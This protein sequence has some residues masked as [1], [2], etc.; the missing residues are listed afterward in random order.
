MYIFKYTLLLPLVPTFAAASDNLS[1]CGSKESL[2][3]ILTTD[4]IIR[5]LKYFT[6]DLA[7]GVRGWSKIFVTVML[8][9]RHWAITAFSKTLPDLTALGKCEVYYIKANS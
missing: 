9:F 4:F 8:I 5:K 2:V 3:K 7:K 1:N 6:F